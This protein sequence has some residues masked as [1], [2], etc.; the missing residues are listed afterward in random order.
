LLVHWA[1][2]ELSNLPIHLTSTIKPHDLV[3]AAVRPPWLVALGRWLPNW[4]W[5]ALFGQSP[6]RTLLLLIACG[7]IATAIVLYRPDNAGAPGRR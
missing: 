5:T 6:H 7:L 2:A 1:P 3:P 4:P